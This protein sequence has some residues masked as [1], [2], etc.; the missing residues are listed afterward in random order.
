MCVDYAAMALLLLFGCP[1]HMRIISRCPVYRISCVECTVLEPLHPRVNAFLTRHVSCN[2]FGS[3][4]AR[5]YMMQSKM[6]LVPSTWD[7]D[8]EFKMSRIAPVLASGR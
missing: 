3:D 7:G 6:V 8:G 2:S 1:H 5:T 4:L